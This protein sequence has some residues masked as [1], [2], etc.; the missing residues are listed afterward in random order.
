MSADPYKTD[1]GAV[2]WEGFA[3]YVD[4]SERSER[5]LCRIIFIAAELC[6]KSSGM[7]NPQLLITSSSIASLACASV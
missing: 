7:G 3:L 5:R 1:I 6:S 2:I 4:K